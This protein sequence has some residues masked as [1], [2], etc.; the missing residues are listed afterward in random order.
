[1]KPF[2]SLITLSILLLVNTVFLPSI[3]SADT[4]V[5]QKETF[6]QGCGMDKPQGLR[7]GPDDNLYVTSRDGIYRINA[8][9]G[10]GECMGKFNQGDP[11]LS[12]TQTQLLYPGFLIVAGN[13][14]VE[15][16]NGQKPLEVLS[17]QTGV[18][19]ATVSAFGSNDYHLDRRIHGVSRT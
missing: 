8:T 19:E 1:M 4:V 18:N 10:P 3:V 12:P 9:D 15:R 11:P 5:V 17:H 6:A 16:G 7:F 14:E 2:F 13:N